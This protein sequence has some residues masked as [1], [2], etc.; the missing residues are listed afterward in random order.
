MFIGVLGVMLRSFRG[1]KRFVGFLGV[2]YPY[3]LVGFGYGIVRV[4]RVSW[5][6]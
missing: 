1:F 2:F 6:F 5:G 4:V 3:P